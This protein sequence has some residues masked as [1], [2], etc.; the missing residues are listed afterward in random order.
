MDFFIKEDNIRLGCR[1]GKNLFK[2]DDVRLLYNRER[3]CYLG[4]S[5]SLGF[6]DKGG[7]WRK[8]DWWHN[9]QPD[10]EKNKKIIDDEIKKIKE[11]EKE[12][13]REAIYGKNKED[14]NN[15]NIKNNLT[16]FQWEK[17][18]K[19]KSNEDKNRLD[20]YDND[21]HRPGLGI[22]PTMKFNKKIKKIENEDIGK[23]EGNIEMY[24]KIINNNKELLNKKRE[25]SEEKEKYKQKEKIHKH[26]HHHHKHYH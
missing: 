16:D 26:H 12:K 25:R 2:W 11:E 1:G 8:R 6:L 5:Q 13:L 4:V 18:M 24:E 21:E 3:E 10:K 15:N 9:Y 14:N 17:L 23:L 7:K 20:F 19:K 22:N